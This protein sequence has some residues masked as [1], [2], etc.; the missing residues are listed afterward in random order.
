MA[1]NNGAPMAAATIIDIRRQGLDESLLKLMLQ[2][3]DSGTATVKKMPTLL[4]YDGW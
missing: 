3:L 4:L 2:S 1:L